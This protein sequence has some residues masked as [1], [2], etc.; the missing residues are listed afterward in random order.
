MSRDL[1]MRKRM[2]LFALAVLLL[3]CICQTGMATE[4][5]VSVSPLMVT[6]SSGDT[7]T[8][9]IVVDPA[10]DEVYGAECTLQFDNTMLKV[11]DQSRGTFLSSDG[12]ETIELLNGI[13]NA[14]G[15]IEYGEIRRGDPEVI[16]GTTDSGV[17]TSINFEAIGSGTC[18]LT[19]EARLLDSGNRPIS[20]VVNNGTC[21]VEGL[22][23]ITMT[24]TEN[25]ADSASAA[26]TDELPARPSTKNEVPGFGVFCSIAGLVVASLLALKGK[27][28]RE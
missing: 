19:L 11:N 22:A 8:L 10:I 23:E 1:M 24:T 20:V 18:D 26:T 6:V 7:F 13:N 28:K 3:T 9:D 15:K 12:V 25:P 4:S 16:G 2:E 17:L 27:V 14:I 5:S 21:S